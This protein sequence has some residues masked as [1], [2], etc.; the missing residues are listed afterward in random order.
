MDV[1]RCEPFQASA[2]LLILQVGE[3]VSFALWIIRIFW[4]FDPLAALL[5]MWSRLVIMP[6]N[7][8]PRRRP[9]IRGGKKS[10]LHEFRMF[11]APR[12]SLMKLRN[13]LW[14]FRMS[15]GDSL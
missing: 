7:P 5:V 4:F 14:R 15:R 10:S 11:T 13:M 3:V 1:D 6:R 2:Y 8:T 9:M 12:A